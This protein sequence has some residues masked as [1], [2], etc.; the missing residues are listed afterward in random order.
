MR[1]YRKMNPC[2]RRLGIIVNIEQ[3]GGTCAYHTLAFLD[4]IVTS[5]LTDPDDIVRWIGIRMKYFPDITAINIVKSMLTEFN[6]DI[7]ISSDDLS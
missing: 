7:D 5:R 1:K 2:F 3:D 4:I 6:N